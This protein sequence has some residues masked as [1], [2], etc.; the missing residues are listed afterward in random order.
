MKKRVVIL[1]TILL[2]ACITMYML[3]QINYIPHGQYT[4]EDFG[5][6][7][8]VSD[9]DQDNDGIDDQTDI[10]ESAKAY[11]KTKPQY[12]SAYYATGYPDD[13][14][15]VC[16][17]VVAFGLLGAGYNLMNLVNEDIQLN[18]ER[19]NIESIDKKIDFRRVTNLKVYFQNHWVA[20]TT[21][22]DK[23]EQWHG[24]DIVIFDKHIGIVSD[25]R[26]KNGIPFVIHHGSSYQRYYIEDILETRTDIWGHFRID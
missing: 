16:T 22:I 6:E 19:Y 4:D 15:G 7:T 1:A 25:K 8:Y 10:L 14:Y 2:V 11:V 17:D 5:I 3:Y 23:I 12:H 13:E 9:R 24:G 21:D 18:P 26:N 20:L